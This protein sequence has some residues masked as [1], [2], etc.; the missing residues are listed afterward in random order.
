M[1][2]VLDIKIRQLRIV[3][4][5][6][7]DE[8]ELEF[9]M[10]V[11]ADDP[12]I[13]VMGSRNGVGKTSVLE[14]CA[15]LLIGL[16]RSDIDTYGQSTTNMLKMIIRS[17]NSQ[18]EIEGKILVDNIEIILKVTLH[19][20]GAI[21]T[22][23]S[24]QTSKIQKQLAQFNK[25]LGAL[26]QFV[27]IVLGK[28]PNPL[29]SGKFIYFPSYRKIQEGNPKLG[30][31]AGGDTTKSMSTFKLTILRALMSRA[32]L[33]EEL[34]DEKSGDALAK[35]NSL[36][37]RYAGGTIQKLRPSEDNTIEFRI[38]PDD[39]SPSFTFDGL[40]SGQKEIISTL[41]LI[42]YHT[43]DRSCVVLIDEP[44][45]HMNPEWHRAFIGQLN[46]LAPQ[47]QYII[48]THSEDVFASVEKDRRLLIHDS[49]RSKA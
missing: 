2:N 33:F 37:K 21:G 24:Q 3:N 13:M 26:G 6:G 12:D 44:E 8:L 38:Q 11:M 20:S 7:I 46:L 36:V 9:P 49:I 4:Y 17:G 39:N 22:I 14:C 16:G 42:W 27:S 23:K 31:I 43:R 1:A 47:N 15:L 35:L 5:K 18:A 19:K 32:Q 10:P 40:S 41:F 48:A 25:D 45:L 30:M 28:N 34:D 29:L